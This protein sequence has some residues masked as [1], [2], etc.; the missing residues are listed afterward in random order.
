MI[1]IILIVIMSCITA[2][3]YIINNRNNL[4]INKCSGCIKSCEKRL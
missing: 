3:L 1:G 4:N 2:G